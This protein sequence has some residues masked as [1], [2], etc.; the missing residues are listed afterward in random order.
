MPHS[1]AVELQPFE[2]PSVRV[3]EL[4]NASDKPRRLR[5]AWVS[6]N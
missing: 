6:G 3:I 1:M 4:D 2:I 5:A